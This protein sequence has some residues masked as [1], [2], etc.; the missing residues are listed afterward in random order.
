MRELDSKRGAG[1]EARS[2]QHLF[3]TVGGRT[4]T[5]SYMDVFMRVRIGAAR[6]GPEL[7]IGTIP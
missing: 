3:E 6:S 1:T 2:G 7:P 4:P 5:Q